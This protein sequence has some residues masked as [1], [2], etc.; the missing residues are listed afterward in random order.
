MTPAPKP[1]QPDILR[2]LKVL[3]YAF[4]EWNDQYERIKQQ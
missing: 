1:L 2:K 3:N 4:D